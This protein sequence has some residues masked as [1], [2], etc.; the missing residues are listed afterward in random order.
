MRQ[1]CKLG[2]RTIIYEPLGFI[3]VYDIDLMHVG[4]THH[5]CVPFLSLLSERSN[6]A[7]EHNF[8]LLWYNVIPLL[9]YTLKWY[10][11]TVNILSDFIVVFL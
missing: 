11:I 6:L 9:R 2:I 5:I 8:M 7:T 10:E 4:S 1:K 3:T